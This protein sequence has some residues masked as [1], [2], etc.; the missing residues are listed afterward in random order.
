MAS[1]VRFADIRRLLERHGWTLVRINGSHHIFQGEDRPLVSIPVHGG[2]FQPQ[3]VRQVEKAI[4]EVV[5]RLRGDP[6]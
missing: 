3:Y 1:E 4:T 6:G 2:R 5:R